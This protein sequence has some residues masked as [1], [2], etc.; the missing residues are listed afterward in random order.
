[1]LGHVGATSRLGRVCVAPHSGERA[2]LRC[3]RVGPVRWRHLRPSGTVLCQCSPS[4]LSLVPAAPRCNNERYTGPLGA[5]GHRVVR[6]GA[7]RWRPPLLATT[8]AFC[9]STKSGAISADVAQTSTDLDRV[10]KEFGRISTEIALS[11]TDNSQTSSEFAH[12]LPELGEL[13]PDFR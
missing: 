11:S 13:R 5:C 10:R 8:R 12:V 3:Q 6:G 2:A 4:F 9:D 1:M 7:K